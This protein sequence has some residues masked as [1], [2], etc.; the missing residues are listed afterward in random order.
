MFTVYRLDDEGYQVVLSTTDNILDADYLVN[1][2]SE[3]LPHAYVDIEES[4]H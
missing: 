2:W 3:L 4:T 1:Y